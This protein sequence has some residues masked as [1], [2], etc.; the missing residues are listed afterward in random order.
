MTTSDEHLW[1]DVLATTVIVCGLLWNPPL[2]ILAFL[3]Y[4]IFD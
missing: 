4:V 3:I 1:T 2:A